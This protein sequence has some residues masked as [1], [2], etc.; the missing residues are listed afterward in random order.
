MAA[1]SSK[2][3]RLASLASSLI[4]LLT[5]ILF[6]WNN[7]EW[8]KKSYPFWYFTDSIMH[9]TE[10]Y[11]LAGAWCHG[12]AALLLSRLAVPWL[13]PP[14]V[15]LVSLPFYLFL[16]FTPDA[17]LL[18]QGVFLLIL[19]FSLLEIGK[20]L[21]NHWAGL[22]AVFLT[23]TFPGFQLQAK[24]YQLDIPL[25]A[26]VACCFYLYLRSEHFTRRGDSLLFGLA[27]LLG[28][29]TRYQMLFYL[30]GLF[31]YELFYRLGSPNSRRSWGLCFGAWLAG[32]ALTIW[33]IRQGWSLSRLWLLNLPV[34][35]AWLWALAPA[36]PQNR[37]AMFNL[38]AAYF[39][40]IFPA[41]ALLHLSWPLIF[42]RWQCSYDIENFGFLQGLFRL[43][44]FELYGLALP[45][46]FLL[47][48]TMGVLFLIALLFA[49]C[50]RAM[51]EKTAPILL[52]LAA[53]P[54]ALSSAPVGTP[55][56]FLPFLPFMALLIAGLP[57]YLTRRGG[58]IA[59]IALILPI[60]LVQWFGWRFPQTFP[61]SDGLTLSDYVERAVKG[62]EGLQAGD[63]FLSNC[64]NGPNGWSDYLFKSPAPWQEDWQIDAAL[65]DIYRNRPNKPPLTVLV[66][67]D[68]R[69][70]NREFYPHLED[71]NDILRLKY[72]KDR[73]IFNYSPGAK[74]FNI[75]LQVSE[76]P[77][78]LPGYKLVK[79]YF[80]PE[81]EKIFRFDSR[82]RH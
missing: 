9:L 64:P 33:G 26:M 30:P 13:Y 1:S 59:L 63:Y 42:N 36:A 45:G 41:A 56:Y 70:G 17:G 74:N 60:G 65:D 5:V 22:L 78:L 66:F 14:L 47:G 43:K 51:R 50:N 73:S 71:F 4:V 40:F 7:L 8:D 72:G 37:R 38:G 67:A 19:A 31:L 46:K 48:I 52:V 58:K 35:G 79:T 39:I 23:F 27:F 49:L 6:V 16:G 25:A 29:F 81:G 32:F 12:G 69:L 10:S 61:V 80:L 15:Y 57:F 44:F 68:H 82:P 21:W 75:L 18:S 11:A 28:F 55:R 54:L 34:L 20:K 24:S 77:L 3:A 2:Y 62:N 53:G 76:K